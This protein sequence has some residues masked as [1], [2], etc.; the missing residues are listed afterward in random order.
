VFQVPLFL[1]TIRFP[2]SEHSWLPSS[3]LSPLSSSHSTKTFG[4]LPVHFSA[5]LSQNIS[6][7]L[8][9]CAVHIQPRLC[10]DLPNSYLCFPSILSCSHPSLLDFPWSV[11]AIVGLVSLSIADVIG[12]NAFGRQG[13]CAAIVAALSRFPRSPDRPSAAPTAP[14]SGRGSGGQRAI[15]GNMNAEIKEEHG[16]AQAAIE[17]KLKANAG[18]S[19]QTLRDLDNWSQA[20]ACAGGEAKSGL[21]SAAMAKGTRSPRPWRF[22]AI[23]GWRDP[24]QHRKRAPQKRED[25]LM[26]MH[27]HLPQKKCRQFRHRPEMYSVSARCAK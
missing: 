22:C 24:W 3:G 21:D 27:R 14:Q 10:F 23:A 25:D 2:S 26:P 17:E 5:S 6:P 19:N 4:F 12:A 11:L 13:L 16:F 20:E 9:Q 7:I 15:L 8:R 18:D 1:H